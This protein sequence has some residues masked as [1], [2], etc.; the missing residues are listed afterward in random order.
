MNM[1]R[2]FGVLALSCIGLQLIG[3]ESQTGTPS[4]AEAKTEVVGTLFVTVAKPGEALNCLSRESLGKWAVKYTATEFVCDLWD[5]DDQSLGCDISLGKPVGKTFTV[6]AKHT[7]SQK[8]VMA[9][10]HAQ[11]EIKRAF[12][13]NQQ[14]ANMINDHWG[15]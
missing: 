3:A 9:R 5:Y 7:P 14:L 6:T 13:K 15:S 12:L 8:I 4:T 10:N 1:N 11:S 2:L